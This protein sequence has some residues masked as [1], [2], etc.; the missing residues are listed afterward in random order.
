MLRI[1]RRAKS[2]NVLEDLE[3]KLSGPLPNRHTTHKDF[4]K[5]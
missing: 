5:M 3:V 2:A 4:F 1:Y